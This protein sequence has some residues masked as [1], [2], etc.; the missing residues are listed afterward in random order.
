MQIGCIFNQSTAIKNAYDTG[1]QI[2]SH[3]WSHPQDFGTL[4]TEDLTFQMTRLEDA[5]AHIIGRKPT[6]MRP[7]FLATGG[8]VL[9]TMATLGYRVITDD[10]DSMDWNGFTV[11]QSQQQFIAAGTS[12]DGHIP[13]MH[14]TFETTVNQLVPWLLDFATQN[15]LTIVTVGEYISKLNCVEH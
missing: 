13:L 15:N 14:E 5:L 4:S 11:E 10:V 1:H 7:P 8:N 9:P 6:Y 2:A 3:S 12:G